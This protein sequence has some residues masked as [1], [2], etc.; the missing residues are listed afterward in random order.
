[1]HS[2]VMTFKAILK[3]KRESLE[4]SKCDVMKNVW[5][6]MRVDVTYWKNSSLGDFSAVAAMAV[7]F[8]RVLLLSCEYDAVSL[9]CD[10]DALTWTLLWYCTAHAANFITS[11]IVIANASNFFRITP[12]GLRTKRMTAQVHMDSYCNC[13]IVMTSQKK[14]MAP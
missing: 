11:S 1:M 10:D 7:I 14:L 6:H 9:P 3:K 5:R 4:F 8:C 12:I 13:V 2:S